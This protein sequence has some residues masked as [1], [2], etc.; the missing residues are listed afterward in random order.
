[1][2]RY[3]KRPTYKSFHEINEKYKT[4]GKTSVQIATNAMENKNFH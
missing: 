2:C 4:E 1:M 3:L